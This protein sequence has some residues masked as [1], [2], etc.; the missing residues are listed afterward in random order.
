ME[1]ITFATSQMMSQ[2]SPGGDKL[3]LKRHEAPVNLPM[4]VSTSPNR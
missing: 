3:I 1:Q 4:S 2:R